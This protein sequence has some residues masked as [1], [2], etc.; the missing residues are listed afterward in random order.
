MLID[1]FGRE[2][3]AGE[4]SFTSASEHHKAMSLW[5]PKLYR[6]EELTKEKGKIEARVLDVARNNPAVSGA[7]RTQ[8]DSI[9]GSKFRLALRPDNR[10]LGLTK[11]Q[12]DDWVKSV[13][14]EFTAY[15]ESPECWIDARRQRT[16]TDLI[17]MSATM[18]IHHGEFFATK[19]WQTS[20]L[21]Y[22]TCFNTIDPTRVCPPEDERADDFDFG[23]RRNS[24]GAATGYSVRVSKFSDPTRVYRIIPKYNRFG[25]LQVLHVFDSTLSDQHRGF[26]RLAAALSTI[27]QLD[28][29]HETELE[30]AIIAASYAMFIK[31]DMPDVDQVFGG[32]GLTSEFKSYLG[33]RNEHHE[34]NPITNNGASIGRLM[35]GEEIETVNLSHPNKA[36][37]EFIGAN[38]RVVAKTIGTSYEE[39]TG[40]LSR[41][42]YAS[43]RVALLLSERFN[44]VK[45]E[46]NCKR[47]ANL[48]F[49]IWLDEAVDR[50][51]VTPPVNYWENR[52]A[53]TRADWITGNGGHIDDLKTARAR[54]VNL[55]TGVQ[56]HQEIAAQDGKDW[57]ERFEQRGREA[58]FK[59]QLLE[60]MGV[61]LS[62]EMKTNIVLGD[63]GGKSA[64]EVE[65]EEP[66]QAG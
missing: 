58:Q 25:W 8:V 7:I 65:F 43:A 19:E 66:P 57:E 36:F 52:A 28:R 50:G 5:N 20:P 2:I 42:S 46:T 11:D 60:E 51:R 38:A 26:S 40:D 31:S 48:M 62:D 54:E 34:K 13:E 35:P 9:V 33:A 30:Q 10:R 18:D 47:S 16:F 56:T 61:D 1:Q 63:I 12:I 22:K 64:T 32:G 37:G 49:R 29:F 39:Y 44:S 17:R 27:K 15:A 53:L 14:S 45:R 24:F 23:I 4:T 59:I 6:T 41:T 21:G 3:R 55:R